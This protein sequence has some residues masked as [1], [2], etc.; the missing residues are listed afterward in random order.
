MEPPICPN[1][2]QPI[3]QFDWKTSGTLVWN[4]NTGTYDDYP[5]SQ[6]FEM[7]CDVC[8]YDVSEEVQPILANPLG[9]E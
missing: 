7:Q 4:P 8:R 1:C 9:G 2:G 6:S 5:G 3:L